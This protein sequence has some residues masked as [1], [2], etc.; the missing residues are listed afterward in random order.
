MFK[1]VDP[2]INFPKM[3]E[4]TLKFWKDNDTFKKSMDQRKGNKEYVF[5]DGPPFATGLPHFGHLVPNTIKDV[6]PRFWTMKG[7]YVPRRFG[8]DCHGLPVEL[9]VEKEKKF[10]SKKD[11]E[12]FGIDN[13]NEA[14]R[15]LVN[16]ITGEWEQIIERYGRWVDFENDYKTMDLDFMEAGGW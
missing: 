7:K 15:T 1:D 13:F 9:E 12:A 3:E 16:E 4:E 6:I 11:I 10:E 2:K 8:W 14:C 5:L